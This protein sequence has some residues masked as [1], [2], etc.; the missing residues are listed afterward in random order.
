MSIMDFP[1]CMVSLLTAA[2]A[3]SLATPWQSVSSS[4]MEIEK[5]GSMAALFMYVL[6]GFTASCR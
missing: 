1:W 3:E 2:A 6:S 4:E 5:G